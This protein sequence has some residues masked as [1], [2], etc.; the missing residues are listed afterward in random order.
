MSKILKEFI[1]EPK[2]MLIAPAGYGKTHS[3]AECMKYTNGKQLILT[4]THA[5]VASLKEKFN[6][7]KLSIRN[8]N[9]ET[10]TGFAQRYF[11]AFY[12][13]DDTPKQE[14][15]AEYYPFI[16]SHATEL[17]NKKLI[18]DIVK[19]T[20]SGLFVDEYQDCAV[21]HHELIL[22]LSDILPAHILGDPLQGI[23][24]F[25][26][27]RLVDLNSTKDMMDFLKNKHQ[28]T[29]P[30]R[31]ERTSSNSKLGVSFKDIRNLLNKRETIDLSIYDAI[32]VVV[33]PETD[34]YQPKSNYYRT[35]NR[36][37]NAEKNLLIIHPISSSIHVRLN[38]IKRFKIPINL[39]EAIDQEDFYR[40]SK[41]W[42]EL[43]CFAD[44]YHMLK[45]TVH[46]MFPKTVLNKWFGN[47]DF[48]KKRDEQ[49]K[50][51][52]MPIVERFNT[53]KQKISFSQISEIFKL[54]KNIPGNKCYRKELFYDLCRALDNSTYKSISVYESM[55]N[56]RNNKRRMGRKLS[57]KCIGTTLLTKGLEFD[58][59]V[60]LDAHKF[61]C[62]KNF[63]VAIT[64]ACKQ[65]VI[66]TNNKILN[67]YKK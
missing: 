41:K 58:T 45:E 23:Y 32:E 35:I 44:V 66:F 11:N 61:D 48:I 3:I 54:I 13:G 62:P 39:V 16:I 4:H 64:R 38:I 55:I 65:L 59:V 43:M 27:T 42:D 9:I 26:K 2:S 50:I 29:T 22:A 1:S 8:Y 7:E 56:I 10:I 37:L 53:L 47:N 46:I 36:L 5:G 63:Y 33:C 14:N 31:W 6:K 34:I 19:I 51:I 17:I 25:N 28:L 57:Q 52:I 30:W 15:A 40:I 20:Y 49:D 24:E 60:V 21:I 12:C 18:S 67:P